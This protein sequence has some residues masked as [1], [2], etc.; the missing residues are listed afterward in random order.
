[1]INSSKKILWAEG[2]LLSQQLFQQW[3]K[4]T[5]EFMLHILKGIQPFFSGFSRILID[6]T[7][8]LSGKLQLKECIAIFPNGVFVTHDEMEGGIVSC[9]LASI[10]NGN[11]QQSVYLC[12]PLGD[13]VSS[14]HGEC[15]KNNTA[16]KARY[17]NVKDIYDH[18]QEKEVG[19]YIPRLMLLREDQDRSQYISLKLAEIY[20]DGNFKYSLSKNFIPT[21]TVISASNVLCDFVKK[22]LYLIEGKIHY[23]T[24]IK[25]TEDKRLSYLALFILTNNLSFFK[26]A[27]HYQC[28]HPKELYLNILNLT[29]SLESLYG[30][31]E[32]NDC[33]FYQHENLTDIFLHLENRFQ[34]AMHATCLSKIKNFKLEKWNECIYFCEDISGDWLKNSNFYLLIQLNDN[35]KDWQHKFLQQVKVSSLS[36]IE[37][38]VGS[39]LTGV[40][41]FAVQAVESGLFGRVDC[42]YFSFFKQGDCWETIKKNKSI[43]I[44]I[45]KEFFV[46][47]LEII[48]V[49]RE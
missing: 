45:P 15:E 13:Q 36:E 25:E 27:N 19:F 29:L 1:M 7:A 43:A 21:V 17:E 48:A 39:A 28:I 49:N 46:I 32:A 6:E 16:W 2:T 40:D 5:E 3:D 31:N 24:E 33:G 44:F 37:S 26:N 30:T 8:L 12:L 20:Y 38:I 4:Q 23:F 14:I 10:S 9:D 34:A 11:N 18:T 42:S 41:L 47:S 35:K 22:V